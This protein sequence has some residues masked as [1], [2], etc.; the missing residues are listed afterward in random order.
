M[1]MW[2][3]RPRSGCCL[4]AFIFFFQAEDGIRDY[5]VTGVQTCA[6]PISTRAPVA[7]GAKLTPRKQWLPAAKLLAPVGQAGV[8]PPAGATKLKSPGFAPAFVMLV[9]F[10]VAVPEL[11]IWMLVVAVVA[12]KFWLP[13][14]T[15][16][17]PNVMAGPLV[18]EAVRWKTVVPPTPLKSEIMKK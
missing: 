1:R 7:V 13:K 16:V 6:L 11:V 5:K 8:A 12:P 3:W 15:L 18:V 4:F 9:L 10:K 2:S 14:G 17:G